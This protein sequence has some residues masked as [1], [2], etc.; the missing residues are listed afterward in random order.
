MAVLTFK[1]EEFKDFPAVL[2][3]YASHMHSVKGNSEKTVCRKNYR[4]CDL[5][6]LIIL[7]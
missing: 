2:K 5:I 7:I 3:S 4:N 1:S 6:F